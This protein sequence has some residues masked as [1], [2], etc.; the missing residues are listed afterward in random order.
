MAERSAFELLLN[1][2]VLRTTRL[3]PWSHV[4]IHMFILIRASVVVPDTVLVIGHTP[5]IFVDRQDPRLQRVGHIFFVL[6]GLAFIWF[7]FPFLPGR[8]C[9]GRHLHGAQPSLSSDMTLFA[10]E[11]LFSH[12]LS[13]LASSNV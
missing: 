8:P 2:F 10:G 13:M 7:I 1:T 11:I 9:S 4:N 12:L 5:T 3:R 6:I